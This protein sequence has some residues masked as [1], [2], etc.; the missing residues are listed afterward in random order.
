M[1]NRCAKS[2]RSTRHDL[3]ETPIY[4]AILT[5]LAESDDANE[6]AVVGI[7]IKWQIT[8]KPPLSNASWKKGKMD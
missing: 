7:F 5:F 3:N 1:R 8:D 4:P 6:A 2:E